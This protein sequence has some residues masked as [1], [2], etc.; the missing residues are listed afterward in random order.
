MDPKHGPRPAARRAPLGR[1]RRNDGRTANGPNSLDYEDYVEL[2]RDATVFRSSCGFDM[3][4]LGLTFQERAETAWTQ[5]V[6][7][8]FF[9]TLGVRP[10]LGRVLSPS[11]CRNGQPLIAV[12]SHDYWV[13][14]FGSDPGW[15]AAPYCSR[16]SPARSSAWPRRASTAAVSGIRMDTFVPLE[17]YLDATKENRASRTPNGAND[18]FARLAPG[19]SLKQ[20]SDRI[21][22]LSRALAQRRKDGDRKW[23]AVVVPMSGNRHGMHSVLRVPMLIL[24]FAAAF[25]FL[26]ACSNVASLLLARGVER[27]AE[28]ALRMA[29][30]GS[31][32]R[33]VLQVLAEGLPLGL[34]AGVL[35][36]L[37]AW[38]SQRVLLGLLPTTHFPLL[39]EPRLDAGAL[40]FAVGLSV[41]T[42]LLVSLLPALVSSDATLTSGMTEGASRASQGRRHRRLMSS[43]IVAELGV[44]ALLLTLTGH[45]ARAMSTLRNA[46]TGFRPEEPARRRPRLRGL[47]PAA[48]RSSA[49]RG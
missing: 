17:P 49:A 47:R 15:W 18:V 38:A 40:L 1:A 31:R 4:T 13:R 11:D 16:A 5:V 2:R 27:Q 3:L 36:I 32:A 8:D 23:E 43:L 24:A 10:S 20:A 44:A 37:A 26:V 41:L 6:T 7:G 29:L 30:G 25:L 21:G 46:P 42:A 9:G 33:L 45:V 39:L 34:A 12:L 22:I 48:G 19:V 35:G 28:F 14:R